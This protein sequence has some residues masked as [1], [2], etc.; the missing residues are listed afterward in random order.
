MTISVG[1]VDDDPIVRSALR[2]QLDADGGIQVVLECADGASAVLEAGRT[3]PDVVLMDVRMPEM[4]G[5]AATHAIRMACPHTRVLLMT[6]IDFDGDAAAALAVG[7]SGLLIKSGALD[8]LADAVRTVHHGGS[9]FSPGPLQRWASM[10]ALQ[11]SKPAPTAC[12]IDDQLTERER[13]V[14]SLLCRAHTNLEIAESLGLAE[15]T[16][17]THVS[18]IMAKLGVTTRLKAVVKAHDLGLAD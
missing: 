12:R 2:S 15:S 11:V 8:A 3:S 17:K 18:A 1:I 10:E 6:A 16:V 7:A 5:I 9:V 13:Q 14:L 4:D